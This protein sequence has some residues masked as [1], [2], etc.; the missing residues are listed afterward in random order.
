M[1]EN[2]ECTQKPEEVAENVVKTGSDM[3][4]T[5]VN[6]ANEFHTGTVIPTLAEG[7]KSLSLWIGNAFPSFSDS[8]Q[9]SSR[10]GR[11]EDDIGATLDDINTTLDDTF[12]HMKNA[13][14][15]QKFL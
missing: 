1:A 11:H 14:I 15:M 12:Y 8:I 6:A 10:W 7:I 2:C 4:E 3:A 9:Y 13:I 5:I